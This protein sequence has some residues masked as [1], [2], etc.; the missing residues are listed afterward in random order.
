MLILGQIDASFLPKGLSEFATF[1]LNTSLIPHPIPTP[2]G[3]FEQFRR[4]GGGLIKYARKYGRV[5]VTKFV[6]TFWELKNKK[7][8][9]F[10]E[11]KR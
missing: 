8:F 4:G 2:M 1:F 3:P 5:W 7:V 6:F 9:P 10:Q 11:V